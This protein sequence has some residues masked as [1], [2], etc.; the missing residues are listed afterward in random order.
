MQKL[1]EGKEY[2]FLIDKKLTLPDNTDHFLLI[3][4]DE[5]KYLIPY[6]RYSHY[7]LL[8]GTEIKCRVD[9]INCK[10]EI[11]LEPRNPWYREG[12]NYDFAISGT[13]FRTDKSGVRRE[14]LIV[15]D[16]A[17]FKIAVSTAKKSLKLRVGS[18][19]NLKVERISKGKIQ[20]SDR[21]NASAIST[22]ESGK[23]YKFMIERVEKDMKDQEC[24]VIKDPA[25]N[26]HTLIKEYYEYY[27][28]RPGLGFRGRVI[29][30]NKNGEL[31]IEPHNPFYKP[32]TKVKMEITG[33]TISEV[34]TSFTLFLKD[35][36]GFVHF[37][38]NQVLP[39]KNTVSCRIIMIKKGKPLIELEKDE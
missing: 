11:F 4:P 6:N 38:E 32:G 3:G 1:T 22:L 36:H 17:G 30:K 34:K 33:Y 27:G 15:T 26:T 23:S 20:L 16:L 18:K 2:K 19:I 29:K 13:E 10:G 8:T 21:Q 5:N 28:F 7:G 14:V 9:R 39:Q 35:K 37:V 12:K 25:G 31:I 24:Y